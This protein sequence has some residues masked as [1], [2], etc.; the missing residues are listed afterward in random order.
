[1]TRQKKRSVCT[2]IMCQT[3]WSTLPDLNRNMKH[4]FD[5]VRGNNKTVESLEEE[6]DA[7]RTDIAHLSDM[8]CGGMSGTERTRLFNLLHSI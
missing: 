5:K 1:M 4:F 7:L 8:C 6:K 2:D 3:G